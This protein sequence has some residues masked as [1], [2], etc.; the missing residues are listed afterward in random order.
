MY[1][2]ISNNYDEGDELFFFGFSRGAFTVRSVAGLVSDVGVLSADQMSNFPGLW[3]AYRSGTPF[4]DTGWYKEHGDELQKEKVP[5]KVIGVWDT[6]GA[7]GIPEWFIVRLLRGVGIPINK[8]YEFHNTRLSENIEY[9]FQALALDEKRLAFPPALW[10]KPD[11]GGPSKALRQCWFPGVHGN[12]G[13]SKEEPIGANTF[14]WMVDNLEDM[15]TFE[16]STIDNF[17]TE[18]NSVRGSMSGVPW[19]CWPIDSSGGLLGILGKRDRTPGKYKDP[20]GNGQNEEISASKTCETF[21]PMV[22]KRNDQ[23][24]KWRPKSLEGFDRPQGAETEWKFTVDNS[25]S[26]PEDDVL[27][28]TGKKMV[29]VAS[30]DGKTVNYEDQESL[31]T[32]LYQE[33]QGTTVTGSSSVPKR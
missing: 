21:H 30:P 19:G 17:V 5:I 7:L 1:D 8:A 6:V 10:F 12:I 32:K 14:A 2:F 22:R 23:L 24:D 25:K 11:G 33:P 29:V 31:S 15:L 13:G 27:V 9:A 16:K 3:A 20:A 18:Y 28:V 4:K 26:I